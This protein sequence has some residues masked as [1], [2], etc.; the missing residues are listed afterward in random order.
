MGAWGL[1][2][3]ESDHDFDQISYM[4]RDAG[5]EALEGK[6]KKRYQREH[7]IQAARD[8]KKGIDDTPLLTIYAKDSYAVD[9]VRK[10]LDS[11][12]LLKLIEQKKTSMNDKT[13]K[14]AASYALYDFVLLGACAMTLGC[15]LPGDYRAQLAAKYR[16]SGL[17]RDAVVQMQMALS[18]GHKGYKDGK[19]Y[20]FKAKT[21]QDAAN[22]ADAEEEEREKSEKRGFFGFT[23]PRL[24]NFPTLIN[25]PAPFGLWQPWGTGAEARTPEYEGDVCGGCGSEGRADGKPL[26]VCGGCKA[27]K[28]CGKV[29][30]AGH[31][32]QHKPFCTG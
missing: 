32:K 4:C 10:H 5:L 29:C 19:P 20:D 16:K 12:A 7:P 17:M 14:L 15:K 30:Q 9:L 22:L 13:D 21:V 18:D 11:G 25:V 24:F 2:L 27:K 23:L 31:Y 26:L 6:A 8:K 1:G 28:Y 3:F